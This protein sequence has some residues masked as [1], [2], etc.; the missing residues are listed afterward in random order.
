MSKV[1]LED[2]RLAYSELS[3]QVQVGVP[4]KRNP[5]MWHRHKYIHNDF[6]HAVIQCWKGTKQIVSDGENAYEISV[7]KVPLKSKSKTP[8]LAGFKKN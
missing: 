7:K 3:E 1:N 8:R 4:S 5:M 6:L 2:I